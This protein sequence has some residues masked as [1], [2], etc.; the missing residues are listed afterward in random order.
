MATP[1]MTPKDIRA[2]R[3]AL[4]LSQAAFAEL[5]GISVR[6][7][8]KLERSAQS[9]GSASTVLAVSRRSCALQ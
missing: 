1:D 9:L 6:H 7:F 8:G 3:I 2:R 4:G 5:V